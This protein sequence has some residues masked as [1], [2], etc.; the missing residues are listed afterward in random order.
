[1]R[2]NQELKDEIWGL[3]QKEYNNLSYK[4]FRRRILSEH[5][6]ILRK[7]GLNDIPPSSIRYFNPEYRTSEINKNRIKNSEKYKLTGRG[8]FVSKELKK[9]LNSNEAKSYKSK[10]LFSL[11][12]PKNRYE[13]ADELAGQNNLAVVSRIVGKCI[14]SLEK[15]KLIKRE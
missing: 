4:T 1:M 13:L 11:S 5:K 12:K 10:I 3:W 6:E 15:E 8:G 14:E 7:Y 2:Y 9:I